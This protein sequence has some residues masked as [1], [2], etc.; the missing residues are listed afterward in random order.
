LIKRAE[1]DYGDRPGVTTDTAAKLKALE[2]ENKELRQANE[3]RNRL[4]FFNIVPRQQFVE[5]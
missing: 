5:L 3:I 1:I 2:R 4:T